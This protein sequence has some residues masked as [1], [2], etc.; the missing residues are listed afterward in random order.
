ES[1]YQEIGRAGRDGQP[2]ECLLMYDERDLATQMEFM[3]WSNPDAEYY[4]RVYDFLTIELEQINAFG[5]DWLRERLHHKQK[6][7]RRLETTLAM[8]DRWGVI[9]GNRQFPL[10]LEVISELPLRLR[11][12]ER[13]DKKLKRDQTKL[14]SML[15]YVKHEGDRKKFI[16]EYFGI[17][18]S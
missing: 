18:D 17:F 13:I 5:L 11:D 9:R 1:Y 6:H 10:H 3:Q 14:Y 16:H 15:Q 4:Q 8:L 12:A 2:S 7:D